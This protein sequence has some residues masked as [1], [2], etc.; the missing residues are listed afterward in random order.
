[1]S[2]YR[3]TGFWLAVA[4]FLAVGFLIIKKSFVTVE[5][6]TGPV[7]RQNLDLTVTAT[8]TGTIK[9]D[10]EISITAQR[11]G[12]LSG[13]YVS[14]GD[15]V[16]KGQ[17]LA[18]IDPAEAKINLR[19]ARASLERA[20]AYLA[21][22]NASLKA[23]ETEVGSGIQSA[24]ARLRE[25]EDRYNN[26]KNLYAEGFVSRMEFA[27][28][29]SEYDVARAG[30]DA[31]LASRETLKAKE[32]ETKAQEA[33]VK[34]ARSNLELAGLN[35]EY[36]F[37]RAPAPGVVTSRPVKH[38]ETV[39]KGTLIAVII[40]TDSLYI[41]A[42]VDEADVGRVKLG[43]EVRVTM[44]AY[45]GKE[46]HGEVYRISPVVLGG[47]LEA[48][49][50]EVRTRLKEKGVEVKHG[51]SADIEVV[52]QS[53]KDVLVIQ[54][55][56]VMRRGGKKFVYVN[57]GGRAVLRELEIG[58]SD[59]TNTQVVSG[60]EEGEAVVI[61]PDVQGLKD[62]SRLKVVEHSE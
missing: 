36:S 58:L 6:K 37:V 8:S 55:Q 2:L 39:S 56:S 22:I 41:E 4:A 15:T 48:R 10:M 50:F 11:T 60:L 42:F 29:E 27:A 25:V 34:E 35:Y 45:P 57:E 28:V 62:G 52:V 61:T 24:G 47:R 3:R 5:V 1:M 33:A 14:E 12:R 16:E 7:L 59:W 9:S 21:Q 44:D 31:A 49:T 43:Q 40:T 54:S 20:T 17:L 53:V 26:L 19:L 30:Y 23:L 13:L 51:M 46:F 38:G 18:E 32:G